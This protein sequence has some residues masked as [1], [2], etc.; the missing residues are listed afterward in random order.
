MDEE[1]EEGVEGK[2]QSF[3]FQ[4]QFCFLR[5]STSKHKLCHDSEHILETVEEVAWLIKELTE[6]AV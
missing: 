6:T 5:S 2:K 1:G 3:H 4:L